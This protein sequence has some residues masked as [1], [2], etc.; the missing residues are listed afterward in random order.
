M[1]FAEIKKTSKPMTKIHSEFAMNACRLENLVSRSFCFNGY[2]V[3]YLLFGT[4]I[5][6]IYLARFVLPVLD[7]I[8]V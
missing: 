2:A 4:P 8:L 7:R 6:D 1:G 5:L 3:G